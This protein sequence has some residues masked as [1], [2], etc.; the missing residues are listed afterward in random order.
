MEANSVKRSDDMSGRIAIVRP[1]E[2]PDPETNALLKELQEGWFGDIG[3]FG[4]IARIP[5]LLKRMVP[6]F[7]AFFAQGVV[8]PQLIELMRLKMGVIN[9]CTYCL[10]VRA[11]GVDVRTKE[12]YVQST[13][14]PQAGDILTEREALAVCLGERLALDPHTVTDEFFEKLQAVFTDEE[15]VNLVFAG[16]I[17]NWGATFNIALHT[18][19][20]GLSGQRTDHSYVQVA[21]V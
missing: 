4:T 6:V 16:S 11:Q 9:D 20:D 18:T 12:A 2:S 19:G 10:D 14:Q 7:E 1:G 3:M 8:E 13:R 5:T 15:I 21:V 17:F